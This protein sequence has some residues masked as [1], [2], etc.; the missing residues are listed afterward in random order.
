M[1]K[2]NNNIYLINPP[3][4]AYSVVMPM[5]LMYISSYLSS[6]G[7]KNEILDFK[8][9][10]EDIALGK[11]LAKLKEEKPRI[12]GTSCLCTEVVYVKHMCTKIKEILPDSKIIVGGAHPTNY[13]QLFLKEPCF[14]FVVIGEGEMTFYELSELLI[15]HGKPTQEQLLS[16]K[17]IA[18]DKNQSPQRP[19][20]QELDRLPMPAYDKIDVE[21]YAKPNSFQ[22]RPVLAS[23]AS[24]STGRGCPFRCRYCVAG[25]VFGKQVRTR[26]AKVA[27]DEAELMLKKYKF[28]AIYFN[29]ESFTVDRQRVIAI[30]DE[31][32]KRK[33]KFIWGCQTRVH[34]IQED[35]LKIMKDAG[36]IQID[37]GVETCSQRL[38]DVIRKDVKVESVVKAMKSCKR[39]G[40]RS[41]VNL[42]T[43]L[44][45]ETKEDLQMTIDI[46]K[47][48]KPNA[49]IWNV[50][51]PYPGTNLSDVVVKDDDLEILN[52]FPSKE[53]YALL[54]K[55][56]KLAEYDYTL[57]DL[58]Y[59]KLYRVFFHPRKIYFNL[60][61]SYIGSF[62]RFIDFI[63]N[64]R[65]IGMLLRSKRKK[66][67]SSAIRLDPNKGKAKILKAKMPKDTH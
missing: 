46:M 37:F 49:I 25:A 19:F 47:K 43:N 3:T 14:D 57:S 2:L 21:Y 44:P 27:V 64:P 48:T 4:R 15:K 35:L 34:L 60:K 26:S 11:I 5:G 66:Q 10:N 63:F 1:V 54:E 13:S 20:I 65:Y 58:V 7:I 22:I 6:K 51:V 12:I 29:E 8:T 55:H 30:C 61:P 45:T 56:Y 33:L 40:I 42:M 31:I 38:L 18:W 62:I 50:T 16:V 24:I 9:T 39:A 52:R 23:V 59:N 67:Y 28:D 36:C 41:F 17:G 32:K 53:A